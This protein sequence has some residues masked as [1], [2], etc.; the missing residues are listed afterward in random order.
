DAHTRLLREAQ[1]MAKIH[2]P[3]VI[4]VHE[5]GTLGEQVYLAMEFADGGT[6]RDWL[7][8][9]R[10]DQRE[11]L[12]AFAQAG[13]GLAAAHAVGL[14]HR[15]FKPDNVLLSQDGTARVTDFGL[16]GVVSE[17][18]HDTQESEPPEHPTGE[19]G[20][21]GATPLTADLTQTGAIMGTPRYMAPEQFRGVPATERTDQFAFC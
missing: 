15:D 19:L 2:H 17:K 18:E 10:R 16:V 5:V 1:A 14:V 8:A 13:R 4:V 21:S 12:G 9:E 6:L 20:R 7:T 3:N 11:I